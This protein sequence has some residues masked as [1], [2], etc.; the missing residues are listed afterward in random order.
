[1]KTFKVIALGILFSLFG[2]VIDG[3]VSTLRGGPHIERNHAPGI[4]ALLGGTAYN[5]F[6]WIV[7]LTG[8]GAAF[9]MVRRTT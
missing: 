3:F 6:F 9:W 7:I 4:S 2:F 1:M 5:P 8:F